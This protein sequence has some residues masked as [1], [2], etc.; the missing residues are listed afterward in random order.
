MHGQRIQPKAYHPLT[1][2]IPEPEIQQYLESVEGVI[3]A[4][5][6]VMPSHD[7]YIAEH[8]KATAP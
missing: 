2:L 7:Q 6:E 1:D 4:C 3:Q 8:C 5:V